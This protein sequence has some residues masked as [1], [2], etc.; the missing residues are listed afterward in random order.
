MVAAGPSQASSSQ[1]R[2]RNSQFFRAGE[3]HNHLPVWEQLLSG[4]S[5]SQVD[6]MEIIQEGVKID[7]F[8]KPFKENFKG[9][10]YDTPLPP[11]MRLDNAKVCEQFRDFI[12]D[13]I[14]DWEQLS[15]SRVDLH[16]DNKVL[17]SALDDDGCRNSAINEVV[18]EIFRCSRDQNFS[19]QTFYVPSK[20]NS[21]DKP[22]RKFLEY[23]FS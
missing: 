15:N 13:T 3:I 1:L 2:F 23:A 14:V 16:I 6:F 12:T 18:K 22:S 11:T 7:R 21:A 9:S 17:K 19:I 8:F 10:S 4:Y 5:S 20:Y